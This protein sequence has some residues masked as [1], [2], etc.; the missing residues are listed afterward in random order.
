LTP[1]LT[2]LTPL[3]PGAT[4]RP[5]QVS[6]ETVAKAAENTLKDLTIKIELLPAILSKVVEVE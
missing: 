1:I 4:A 2:P 3:I 6:A 5:L